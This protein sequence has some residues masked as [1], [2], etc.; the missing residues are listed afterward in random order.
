[1]VQGFS[2]VLHCHRQERVLK[3]ALDKLKRVLKNSLVK[4]KL[5]LPGS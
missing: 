3:K 1:V 2:L 5:N 4:L